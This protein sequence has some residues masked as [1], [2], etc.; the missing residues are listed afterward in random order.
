MRNLDYPC[1]Y[2]IEA[3]LSNQ[4]CIPVIQTVSKIGYINQRA[5]YL[6]SMLGPQV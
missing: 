3:N 4:T 6:N 2:H 5:L 1:F